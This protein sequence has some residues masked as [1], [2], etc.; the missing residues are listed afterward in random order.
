MNAQTFFDV[1]VTVGVVRSAREGEVV[2]VYLDK[3]DA[4]TL[5][6]R[7]DQLHGKYR[8]IVRTLAEDPLGILKRF[9]TQSGR[10]QMAA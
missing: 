7:Y 3:K 6:L 5:S 1:T 8:D 10:P 2:I 4:E 9:D